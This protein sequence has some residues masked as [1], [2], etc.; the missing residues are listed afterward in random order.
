MG[1][2]VELRDETWRV[3]YRLDGALPQSLSFYTGE[4]EQREFPLTSGI[5]PYGDTIFNHRQMPQ[6]FFQWK[7]LSSEF[8][9]REKVLM[10][11][12]FR[13]AQRCQSEVHVYLAFI[14]D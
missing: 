14:G 3:L 10:D 2:N 5:D 1:I 11:E 8:Q 13:L 7:V 4:S 12:V 9:G 6:F